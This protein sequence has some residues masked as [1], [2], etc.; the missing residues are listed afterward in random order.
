MNTSLTWGTPPGVPPT[1]APIKES[2]DRFDSAGRP[3]TVERFGADEE[4]IRA[5]LNSWAAYLETHESSPHHLPLMERTIQSRQLFTV[6]RPDDEAS[7]A[8]LCE[9][10]CRHLAGQTGG[11]FQVD[12]Q[13]FFAADGTLL[14]GEP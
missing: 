1:G 9:A 4:G 13:G 6:E 10:L 3:I 14:V 8:R 2:V 12:E 7:S 11:F 5:E